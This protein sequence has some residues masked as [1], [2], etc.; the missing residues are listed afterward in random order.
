MRLHLI[1]HGETDWNAIRRIQG[2]SESTL[3]DNGKQQAEKLAG[4]LNDIAIARVFCSSSVRTRETA[5]I[6]FQQSSP[7][8][9][10]LDE[11]REIHLGPWEGRLYDDIEME[12]PVDFGHFWHQPHL[13]NVKGAETF[14]QLQNRAIKTVT[15]ICREFTEEDIAIVSH[16]AL[17]K[18]ILCH[19]EEKPLSKLWDPPHMH[20]CAHSILELDCEAKGEIIRYAGIDRSELLK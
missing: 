17:I 8:F 18:T 7:E 4:L 10:F 5:A 14:A 6:L 3:S 11:L 1:R 12:T 9:Q 13:F 19:Y 20:N 2:Q 15:S 16:G